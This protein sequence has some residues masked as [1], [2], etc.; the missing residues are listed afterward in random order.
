[1]TTQEA[2]ECYNSP[3]M[4]G[5]ECIIVPHPKIFRCA[6]PSGYTGEYC[7]TVTES[8]CSSYIQLKESDRHPSVNS[9][10]RCDKNLLRFPAW[11]RISENAGSIV[12]NRCVSRGSCGSKYPG[13]MNGTMPGEHDG[14]VPRTI[15]FHKLSCCDDPVRVVVKNCGSFFVYHLVSLPNCDFGYC[16]G[17]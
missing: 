10:S 5:G 3:C 16:G 1:M 7:E 6:C 4:N 17:S 2:T 13:W 9:S 8:E 11:Y 15:C 12:T 14:I